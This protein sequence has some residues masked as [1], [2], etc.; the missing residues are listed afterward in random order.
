MAMTDYPVNVPV[1]VT[2]SIHGPMRYDCP[3]MTWICHGWDG[4]G[5]PAEATDE[6]LCQLLAGRPPS[7]A[8]AEIVV[9]PG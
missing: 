6:H 9:T 3:R 1:T 2:C 5:C 4:E 7:T 8:R